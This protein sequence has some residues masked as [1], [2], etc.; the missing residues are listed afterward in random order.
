MPRKR[1]DRP[2]LDL[3]TVPTLEEIVVV[4]GTGRKIERRE[5][6]AL[7]VEQFAKLLADE[8]VD[9]LDL[10]LRDETL[11]NAVDDRQLGRSLLLRLEQPLR[12][13]EEP[14]VLERDAQAACQRLQQPHVGFRERMLALGVF[15]VNE[16]GCSL[17]RGQ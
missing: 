17:A 5:A 10:E 11:L 15:Q 8:I 3:V 7:R 13:V 6:D 16:T 2:I 12:F 9:R 1:R 4:T 14:R